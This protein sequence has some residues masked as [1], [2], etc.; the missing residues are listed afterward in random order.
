MSTC[1]NLTKI[2]NCFFDPFINGFYK[3]CCCIKNKHKC[4]ICNVRHMTKKELAI[5]IREY[6]S[7]IFV[8]GSSNNVRNIL[9][10]EKLI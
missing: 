2:C 3:F 5:H 7:E 10:Q 8:W 4:D 6:H 1:E 9:E